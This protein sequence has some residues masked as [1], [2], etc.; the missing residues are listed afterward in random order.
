MYSKFLV[1]NTKE[2]KNLLLYIYAAHFDIIALYILVAEIQNKFLHISIVVK[3]NKF[4]RSN[5]GM[6]ENKTNT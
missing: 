4:P 3:N 5:F 2:I 6:V 1:Y